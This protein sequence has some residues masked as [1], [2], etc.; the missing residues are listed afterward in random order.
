MKRR[1]IS[2]CIALVM[3][4]FGLAGCTD[5]SLPVYERVDSDEDGVAVLV[6]GVKYV[7]YPILKWSVNPESKTIAYAGSRGT[8]VTGAVG[9]TD[10]NFLYL[11]DF[12]ASA[13]Y[14]PLH[15][16]D[17]SIPEPSGE[18]VGELIY[19]EYDMRPDEPQGY[20]NNIKDKE[21]I[22]EYFEIFESDNKI[23]D[24]EFIKDC[25]IRIEAYSEEVPGAKYFLYLVKKDHELFIGSGEEGYV[26]MPIDLLEKIAGHEID[27]DYILQEQN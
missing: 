19:I 16:T 10:K 5:Q 6:D 13:F 27:L 3:L 23:T 15:R 1:K 22:K 9:D 11:C 26:E 12:G 24:I 18:S 4:M 25:S 2:L 21:I 14:W 20:S 8:A 7:M 17:K